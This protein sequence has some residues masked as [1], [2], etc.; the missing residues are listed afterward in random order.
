MILRYF[1][2]FIFQ[3][4]NENKAVIYEYHR[5]F[6]NNVHPDIHAYTKYSPLGLNEVLP[7]C[8]GIFTDKGLIVDV[9]D[10]FNVVIS[11]TR[12]I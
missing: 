4:I 3:L 6:E 2:I 11:T 1:I 8:C 12:Y 5:K 10:G 9:V 7:R